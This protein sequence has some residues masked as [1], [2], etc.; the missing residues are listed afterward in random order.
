MS[1]QIPFSFT[2]SRAIV[3]SFATFL[4]ARLELRETRGWLLRD[5][6]RQYSTLAR[7]AIWFYGTPAR[8]VPTEKR[9]RANNTAP[10]RTDPHSRLVHTRTRT[11]ILGRRWRGSRPTRTSSSGV[12]R[13]R[14]R[15]G[16][17]SCPRARDGNP[18]VASSSLVPG[19]GSSR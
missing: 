19:R 13:T 17:F 18:S 16:L 4:S 2:R 8:R 15:I 9:R 6:R 7:A 11:S 3:S 12:A 1:I 10:H 14:S 5:A